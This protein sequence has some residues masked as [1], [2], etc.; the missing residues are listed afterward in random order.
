MKMMDFSGATRIPLIGRHA[1]LQDAERRIR[2]G[3]FH[4]LYFEGKGGIG[5]TALLEA[6]LERSRLRDEM[7]GTSTVHVAREVID[8]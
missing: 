2:Q 7:G 3:G 8:L 5:K 6:I 1:L 4:L